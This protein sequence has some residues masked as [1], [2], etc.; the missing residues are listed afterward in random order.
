MSFLNLFYMFVLYPRAGYKMRTSI[1]KALKRRGK[2]IRTALD[3]YNKLA[4]QMNPPAPIL[5]WKNIVNYTF[6]SEFK[7]L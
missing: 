1:W 6:V 3:K 5:D 4:M 7:I 2:A